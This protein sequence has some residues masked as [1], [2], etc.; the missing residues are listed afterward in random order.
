LSSGFETETE[1]TVHA[2]ALRM[3]M[4]EIFAP[5]RGRMP[6]SHSKLNTISDGIR[7]DRAIL[8]LI[9]HERPLPTFCLAGLGMLLAGIGLGL[10]VVA[11]F[12]HTGLVPRLPTA[13]LST[14][15]VLLAVLSAVCGLI[16]DAVARGRKEYKRIAYLTIPPLEVPE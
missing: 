15:L 11:E 3:P 9:Q 8:S 16:L 2:L 10:P 12:L 1:F 13:L 5:Y 7:I 14:G 6:G 4:Q